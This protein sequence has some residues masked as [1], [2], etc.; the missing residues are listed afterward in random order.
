MKTVSAQ[1]L[2]KKL[3]DRQDD[4]LFID[5][6]TP[7]EFIKEHAE[8]FENKPLEKIKEWGKS[9]KGKITY[10]MGFSELRV[11][12]AEQ[13]LMKLF[14]KGIVFICEGGFLAWKEAGN[15]VKEQPEDIQEA[16][17]EI[18]KLE[19]KAKH[20]GETTKNELIKAK[21]A[22]VRLSA[23]RQEFV[24]VGV[25]LLFSML[26][27]ALGVLIVFSL[28]ILFLFSGITG[29]AV[30]RNFLKKMPWSKK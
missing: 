12:K 23:A 2:K 25:L 17:K 4:D 28:G 27:E 8:G 9:S 24:I 14:P 5:I 16:K 19:A 13:K 11:K 1:D 20:L 6:R 29:K 18:E 26:F 10:I 21:K 15:T 30:F 7:E 3:Q 22:F